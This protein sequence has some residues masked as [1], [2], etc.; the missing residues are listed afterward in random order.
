MRPVHPRNPVMA[1]EPLVDEGVVRGQQIADAPVVAYLTLDEQF[2][3][4]LEGS[5]KVLVELGE[6]LGIRRCGLQIADLQP[7]SEEVRYER[8]RARIEEHPLNLRL[9]D[10]RLAQH[11]LLGEIQQLIVWN[12]APEKERQP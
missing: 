3:L 8:L 2:R 11:T 6:H 12:T 9:D 7:L 1:R 5:T 10:A 4:T